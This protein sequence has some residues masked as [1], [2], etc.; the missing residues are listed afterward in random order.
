M[1]SLI[2]IGQVIANHLYIQ[3]Y[4]PIYNC[5]T[6][7]VRYFFPLL[8]FWLDIA[9]WGYIVL[10]IILFLVFKLIFLLVSWKYPEF[11]LKYKEVL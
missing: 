1:I 2:S 6:N 11:Y 9:C 10:I 7:I 8:S 3:K 4:Y 5:L